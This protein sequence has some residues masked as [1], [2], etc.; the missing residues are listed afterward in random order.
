M[1]HAVILRSPHAHAN[2]K[3]IDTSRAE[4]MEGVVKI[5]TGK[6]FADTGIVG[7]PCGWQVN[8]KNGDVM[9]EPPHPLLVSDKVLHTGDGVAMIIADSYALAK[10]AAELI[11]VDYEPLPSVTNPAEAA[12]EGAPQVHPDVPNNRCFDWELGNPIADVDLGI[13]ASHHVTKLEFIN[14]RVVPNAMEPRSAIGDYD[15]ALDKYTLYTLSLIH[16]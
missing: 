14:Q 12:K 15:S 3:G 6:D 8:F 16:I 5:Y 9:K 11:V 4:A 13:A 7:V 1:L 10:D 2:I